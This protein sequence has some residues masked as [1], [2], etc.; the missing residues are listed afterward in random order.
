MAANEE[1]EIDNKCMKYVVIC[2]RWGLV[3]VLL[4]LVLCSYYL[5]VV[6]LCMRKITLLLCLGL[7]NAGSVGD[8]LTTNFQA[9]ALSSCN[10]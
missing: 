3:V 5:Y 6:V 1:D 7:N 4:A 8:D 10:V 2:A 9:I